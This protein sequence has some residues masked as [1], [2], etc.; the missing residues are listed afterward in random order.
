MS[1]K[2]LSGAIIERAFSLV[3]EAMFTVDLQVRRLRSTEPEDAEFIFRPWA[4]FSFLVVAL[5]RLRAAAKAFRKAKG[6]SVDKALAA[7]DN[8]LPT[9]TPLRDVAEHIEDYAVG[10]GKHKGI[11]RKSLAVGGWDGKTFTWYGNS[12]DVDKARE[13]AM[14]LFNAVR[15]EKNRAAKERNTKT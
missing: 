3:N 11:S 6:V 8:A 12:L 4:D 10:T 5:V 7:F 14:D 13:A 15:D 1:D 9:L 2:P